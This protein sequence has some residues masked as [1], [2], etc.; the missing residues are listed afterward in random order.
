MSQGDTGLFSVRRPR[1][2]LGGISYNSAIPQPAS[3]LKRSNSISGLKEN[4]NPPH[5]AH[6]ARG[7]SSSRMSLA[8]SRPQQP[9]F[10][11]SSSGNN[12]ADLGRPSTVQRTSSSNLFG[13]AA[14]APRMSYA[15]GT[16]TPHNLAPALN[17]SQSLPRR[18][19]V[20]SRPSSTGPMGHQSFFSQAPVPAGVPRDPRPLKDRSYQAKIGQE[21]LDYL[22]QNNFE[23]EMKHSLGQNTL[24]SPTQKDFNIIFQWLYHRIDPAYRFQKNID[25]E[26]PPI[27]KQLRYP[28]EKSI[29][30]SQIAA[31]GGQNW[32]TF[33]GMLH[34]MMQLAQMMDKYEVGEYD[35]ACAEAGVDVSGDRII[36]RFLGGAYRDWL[37]VEDGE[38]EEDA[39]KM[40]EP[41][42]QAMAAEFERGNQ[43][44]ADEMK[45]LEAENASLR[46]QIEEA[47][48]NAPDIAKLDSHFNILQEDTQKFEAYIATIEGKIEKYEA[49]NHLL[50]E[51]ITKTVADLKEAE[52]E[53]SD[54]QS[55]V[56][57]QGITIQD[58]DRMNVERDR[59]Q[60]STEAIS[61]KLDET[62]K[63]SAE[64]ESLAN[65]ALEE[66]ERLVETYNNLCYRISLIPSTAANAKGKDF[67]L[68]FSTSISTT[69]F[70][71]SQHTR[72]Q[73]QHDDRLLS[74]P[75]TGY[76][77]HQI[78]SLD[79][80]TAIKPALLSLRKEISERRSQAIDADMKNHEL[81]DSIKEAIDDKQSEVE[82]LE[83]R[84]RAA[85][86]EFEKT[87][88][89]CQTQK[90]AS[91][92][93]IE[94]MEKEL[95]RMRSGL[96]ES[97]QVM[98]QREMS[99]N[100]EYEQLTLRANALREELHTEIERMLNDIIKFKV[101]I[102]KSLEDYEGFV[103]EEVEQELGGEDDGA[104]AYVDGGQVT[105]Q[106]L[107]DG[108][109]G[110]IG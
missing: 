105:G 96:G 34:W 22:T 12:L 110:M 53:R 87:R 3:A 95:A 99:V 61:L 46:K 19:S 16:M 85:E 29:T 7:V 10:Q 101:H 47:E 65:H 69:N 62:K 20:Y 78:L 49:R 50:Q 72:H 58:I 59:L 76:S 15:P 52:E 48:R 108:G 66:L 2:T 9:S 107:A 73:Q 11:R 43:R 54:L 23:M 67:E 63:R 93:Q 25:A 92:A 41:H 71:S 24:K 36:F 106:V 56:D 8:P 102:Q 74:D 13:N 103:V 33:L 28:Y 57:R 30:K 81:L 100:I 83:H 89:N 68:H 104:E 40:I 79:L 82:A 32:S 14:S 35:D 26:V 109:E 21:L 38:D 55:S 77:P 64:K 75:T 70:N 88:E 37:Q 17:G 5:T 18:S 44:Y 31:V 45:L 91:D 98:E 86:E 84:V 94:R 4:L 51:E 90:V 80:R 1:E 42:V 27:L 6:H 60:K 97:V 39:D